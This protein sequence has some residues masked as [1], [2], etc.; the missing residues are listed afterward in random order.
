MS[1]P[2]ASFD[3]N[4]LPLPESIQQPALGQRRYAL[5][6]GLET[7]DGS[8]Q[9][10]NDLKD[11]LANL[12]GHIAF[13]EVQVWIQDLLDVWQ[14]NIPFIERIGFVPSEEDGHSFLDS[15]SLRYWWGMANGGKL[16]VKSK[17]TGEFDTL[18]LIKTLQEGLSQEDLKPISQFFVRF[19]MA[20][21]KSPEAALL[22]KPFF[23]DG[24]GEQ[25]RDLGWTRQQWSDRLLLVCGSLY[26][27]VVS[28]L[29]GQ[30]LDRSLPKLEAG[31]AKP[32][33]PRF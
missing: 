12:R 25:E 1:S 11:T 14:E 32:G 13:L 21:P 28:E 4:G 24:L 30:E 17:S 16:S 20:I 23:Y 29:R 9:T 26:P 6:L 18:S 33:S 2:I 27:G 8:L 15:Q 10:R 7:T 19:F 5:P 22:L 3:L 31:M